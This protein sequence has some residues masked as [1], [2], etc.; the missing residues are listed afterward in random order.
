[1]WIGYKRMI[2]K[3]VVILSW[4]I[5]EGFSVTETFEQRPEAN[6]GRSM[7]VSSWERVLA[8]VISLEGRPV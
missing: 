6:R 5:R 1:M 3:N 7:Y 2:K 8:I 4:V